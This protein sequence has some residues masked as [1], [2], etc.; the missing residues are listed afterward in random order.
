M[1]FDNYSKATNSHQPY[2]LP[3]PV[4]VT[5]WATPVALTTIKHTL[6]QHI[7]PKTRTPKIHFIL[8]YIP[9]PQ[10]QFIIPTQSYR[11]LYLSRHRAL[12]QGHTYAI[13]PAFLTPPLHSNH[14][15][16]TR[17]LKVT[18]NNLSLLAHTTHFTSS[19][20]PHGWS[21]HNVPPRRCF[22]STRFTTVLYYQHPHL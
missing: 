20:T 1:Y 14:P 12:P 7:H 16:H 6:L 11:P 15:W 2:R 4:S 3:W 21:F 8:F 10:A 18:H 17:H 9:N 5:G 13:V 19:H 22:M